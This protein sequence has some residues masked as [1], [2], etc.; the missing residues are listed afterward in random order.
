MHTFWG[1]PTLTNDLRSFIQSLERKTPE[2]VVRVKSEVDTKY[3][4]QAYVEML[5]KKKQYPLLVFEK[6]KGY[7][8]PVL[9]NM[10][11][12]RERLALAL[13]TTK[14]ALTE[15]WLKREKELIKPNEVETGPVK[16]V[17][18]T[19]EVDVTK[20][21]VITHF[22]EDGGPYIS[23]GILIAK[24]PDTGI[25]NVS[26][27]RLQIKG[28]DKLGVS[29]HTRRHLWD[30]QRRAE[31][32]GEPLEVAIAIG[33]HPAVCLGGAW[34]GT[35][36]VDEYEVIGGFL[37]EPLELVGCETVD[38]KVPARAE[39]VLEG[40]ILP[41]VREPEGPFGEFTG[42]LSRRSTNHVIKL[43]G[44]SHRSDAIYQDIACGFTA[45]HSLLGGAL[46][47]E[48]L[49]YKKVREVVPTV[50]NVCYPISGTCRFHC[51]ISIEKTMEGQA[52]NAILA[53]L[54][55]DSYLKLVVVVDEDIDVYDEPQVLW[56][57]ATRMQAGEDVFIIPNRAASLL[58]PSA[59]LGGMSDV[60]GI[61]A[62]KPLEGWKA[63]KISIPEEVRNLVRTKFSNTN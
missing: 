53:A 54:A 26:F 58:D 24:D 46:P 17:V 39:I 56:A 63:S 22:K 36:E 55:A 25:G 7:D 6:V 50:K 57:I 31:K 42:Y 33:N 43:K 2:E 48:G 3:E 13:Q 52:K 19:S 29:L 32:R 16:E 62:T 35:M 61:D 5:E 28:R 30:Y 37:G 49:V 15:E 8:F 18:I 1:W 40:E 20:F 27:H 34:L 59:K 51:Y 41:N 10:H 38:V 47:R 11:A 45:E 9:T 21:P 23:G 4:I 12:K 60:I 14:D 44:I